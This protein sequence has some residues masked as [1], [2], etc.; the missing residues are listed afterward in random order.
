MRLGPV[1]IPHSWRWGRLI[2]DAQLGQLGRRADFG[3]V[4]AQHPCGDTAAHP[5]GQRAVN[6]EIMIC[7]V[8]EGERDMDSITPSIAGNITNTSH[9]DSTGHQSAVCRLSSLV[10]G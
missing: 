3:D 4:P 1:Q 9:L 7:F 5:D 10:C 6:L 2:V 8:C